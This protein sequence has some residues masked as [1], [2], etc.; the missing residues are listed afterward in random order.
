MR[1]LFLTQVLP[2]PLDAGPKVRAYYV[3]RYLAERGH[4]LTLLSFVRPSDTREGL[5][6]LRTFC[7]E[8]VTVPMPRSRWRD[9]L[10]LVRSLTTG[11]PFLIARD[12]VPAMTE[13]VQRLAERG[14]FDAVHADQLWMAP[15]ALQSSRLSPSRSPRLILDQH[16]AVFQIPRRLAASTSNPLAR[17]LLSR[18]ARL[19]AR[20]EADII[21]QFDHV[22]WV[23]EEDRDAVA[24]LSTPPRSPSLPRHTVIPICVDP[25]RKQPVARH[26][27]A[28]RVTFL[29]GLHWPPNAAG[30]VWF[31]REVWPLVLAEAPDALLTIIGKDPPKELRNPQSAI[32]NL[33]VTGYVTDLAPY[34]Q[35]TAVFIVPL[36]AG[37]GMRVKIL[38]A[39][40]WG[41]PIVSTT[42]GAEGLRVQSGENILLA[43]DAASFARAVVRVLQ[44]RELADHLASAGRATVERAYDWRQ[45]YRAWDE[46]YS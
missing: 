28:H 22:V 6:H 24:A 29:G 16:N 43:D 44:H 20:Y 1:I 5:D 10:A 32:R 35:E 7:E 18:E 14:S 42:I 2:Y 45:V 15:Y 41:L 26:S 3:L 9:G 4:R 33:D 12:R 25:Q 37:G 27:S 34:L 36:H 39:W 19:M 38:D 46:V 8:V 21:R 17:G 31:A 30:V 23:T 11:E 13:A 40:A